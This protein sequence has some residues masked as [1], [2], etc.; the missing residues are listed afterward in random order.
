MKQLSIIRIPV[1]ILLLIL[2]N[3]SK[4]NDPALA[5]DPRDAWVGTW[6]GNGTFVSSFPTCYNFFGIQSPYSG[7]SANFQVD[8]V[9]SSTNTAQLNLTFTSSNTSS[10]PYFSVYQGAGQTNGSVTT[11]L[12]D[13]VYLNSIST[14]KFE[15]P[16][17]IDT[18]GK[19]N[20]SGE[21]LQNGNCSSPPNAPITL[22]HLFSAK[23]TRQ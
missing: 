10:G 4:T 16:L 2:T 6:R 3:C 20:F 22:S 7:G 13:P 14:W 1:A 21:V 5:S 19:L 11:G 23:L 17:F 12:F 15:T 9:A 18:D 8:I